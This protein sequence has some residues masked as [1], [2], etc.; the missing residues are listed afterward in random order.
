MPD[1]PELKGIIS[2]WPK[3]PD[4]VKSSILMLVNAALP[5]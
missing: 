5:K 3:L 2:A 1:D 4:P